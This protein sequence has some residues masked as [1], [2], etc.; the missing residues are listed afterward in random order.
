MK[1]TVLIP[2]LLLAATLV[3]SLFLLRE[4]SR[5]QTAVATLDS[6]RTGLQAELGRSAEAHTVLT[7]RVNSLQGELGE[8]RNRSSVQEASASD[9]RR[10]LAIVRGQLD[11]RDKQS[12]VWQAE[13]ANLRESLALAK[14][15]VSSAGADEIAGYQARIEALEADLT[16]AFERTAPSR[17]AAPVIVLPTT[18]PVQEVGPDSAFVVLG[19]GSNE[20]AQSSQ[21]L[22]IRRGTE[23]IATVL[24]TGVEPHHAIAQVRPDTLRAGLHKG[25]LA[26]I[27]SSP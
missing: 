19:F 23:S 11:E 7:A 3:T 18:V 9:L 2:S 27:T 14:L 26:T 1:I 20:G 25:D 8:T 15:E 10:E 17:P 16:T 5:L 12:V 24:I 22:E 13:A 21:V 4:R 6:A